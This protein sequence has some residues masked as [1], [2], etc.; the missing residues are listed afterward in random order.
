MDGVAIDTGSA[1]PERADRHAGSPVDRHGYVQR[2]VGELAEG[3]ADDLVSQQRASSLADG[4]R[5][6]RGV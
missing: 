3:L 5:A 4:H 1:A 2:G 6:H